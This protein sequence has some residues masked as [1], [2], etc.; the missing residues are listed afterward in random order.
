M[1]KSLTNGIKSQLNSKQWITI[2]Q[3][4]L[5]SQHIE[6]CQTNLSV[7]TSSNK[8]FMSET[9]YVMELLVNSLLFQIY[10]IEILSK[11]KGSRF[12]CI[13]GKILNNNPKEKLECLQ[14]LKK[15]RKKNPSPLKKIY[16][17]KKSNEKRFIHIP[18]ITRSF[19]STIICL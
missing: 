1:D 6:K 4:K 2:K 14:E 5:L 3:K 15:F 19:S 7:L 13:D 8:S 10:A 12:A 11:N 17:S 16:I 18:C 9:F